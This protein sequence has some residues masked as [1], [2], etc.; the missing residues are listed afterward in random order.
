MSSVIDLNEWR[1]N[2][3]RSLVCAIPGCSH[4]PTNLC[5]ICSVH[6]CYDHVTSHSHINGPNNIYKEKDNIN[7]MR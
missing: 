7:N 5:P 4:K 1:N 6:Y 3:I 2:S